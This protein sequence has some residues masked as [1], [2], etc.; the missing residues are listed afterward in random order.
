MFLVVYFDLPVFLVHFIYYAACNRS[1]K[2]GVLRIGILACIYF[3]RLHVPIQSTILPPMKLETLTAKLEERLKLPLPGASA[4][5]LM[6]ATP[7]GNL[8]GL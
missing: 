4:H 3:A 8:S 5:N 7:V 6:R 1:A 2:D